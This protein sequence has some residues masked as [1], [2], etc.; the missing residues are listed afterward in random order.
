MRKFFWA[1]LIML[2]VTSAVNAVDLDVTNTGAVGDGVTDC[3]AAFQK[4]L[5][6]AAAKGGGIVNVP[7]GHYRIDGRLK[8]PGAVTLQG[9]FRT[10]PADQREGRLKLDGSVLLAYAGRGSRDGEPFIRLAGSMATL[11][12]FM[13]TYPEWKQTDVPPILYPPTVLSEGTVNTAILD[14]CFLN[15]YEAI[16][17][18]G[19]ARFLV[20][21]V[22]GY[23]TFRGLYVDACGD[24]GRVE[25][26]HFWPFGVAYKADDPFCKWVNV[27]GVAFEFARTDWQYV[28]NTF[29]FG[30]GVGY[31]FSKSPSGTCNGNFLGIGADCCRRAVLVEDSQY[32]GLLITNGEFVGR[33]SSD[34]SV[35]LEIAEAATAGKVS[36]N[37]CSF[38]GPID[39]CIWQRSAAIQ[40]SAIGTNFCSWDINKRGEPA[41]QI[42]AGKAIIQGNTFGPGDVHVLV[43]PKV[44]SAICMS[45]QA[46]GGFY[47]DNRAGGRTQVVAN[48]QGPLE[49][50]ARAKS[51]YHVDIGS[52]GDHH[53]IRKCYMPEACEFPSVADKTMRWSS[54]CS[55]FRLP[56]VQGKAYTVSVALNL[57]ASAVDKANGLYL[58][59]QRII[60]LPDKT[61]LGTITGSIPAS[62]KD[63]VMLILKVKSW[64]PKDT[65]SSSLDTRLLGAALLSVTMKADGA[66]GKPTNANT[67]E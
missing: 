57:P 50:S 21:N 45:N 9:T 44:R 36:L 53:Y 33:W 13:I 23:P 18:Q 58:G 32:P 8:I 43:G 41:I 29:C 27:N 10:P 25:N 39:R 52:P 24:I 62:D 1:C 20:R 19:A 46:D 47:V 55:E 54:D 42:D 17:Y 64:C 59:D 14:C 31:K 7:A 22:H 63:Y 6:A 3:T 40:F 38:W 56:V 16:R 12:G 60:E 28:T 2:T 67:G 37:N 5:D 48:E 15:S 26:V 65:N 49:M 66:V 4:V 30:Y 11:A 51:C 61:F 35:C 34:D